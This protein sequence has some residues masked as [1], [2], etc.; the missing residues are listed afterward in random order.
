MISWPISNEK[1]FEAKALASQT[2]SDSSLVGL[3]LLGFGLKQFLQIK[4]FS[5]LQ[6]SKS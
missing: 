2:I 3:L 5:T 4:L 6:I 1:Y